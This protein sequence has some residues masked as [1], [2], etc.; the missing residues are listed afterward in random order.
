LSIQATDKA[1]DKAYDE[2]P[3]DLLRGQGHFICL[4]VALR[5]P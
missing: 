5:P 4:T 3:P 1:Y 2:G